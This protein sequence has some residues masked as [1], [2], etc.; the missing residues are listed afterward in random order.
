LPEP[1]TPAITGI[2]GDSM[3]TPPRYSNVSDS[4][5]GLPV[6]EAFGRVVESPGGPDQILDG[7]RRQEVAGGQ[8]RVDAQVLGTAHDAPVPQVFHGPPVP[9][10]ADLGVAGHPADGLFAF[11]GGPAQQQVG[12]ALFRDDVAHIVAVDHHRGQGHARALAHLPGIQALDKG[13]LHVLPEGLYGLD[14]Q[15]PAP[16]HAGVPGVLATG[17][18]PGGGGMPPAPGVRPHVRRA[19]EPGDAPL[20]RRGAVAREV[21]LQGGSDEE[22]AGV[23]A[24]CLGEGPVGPHGA[25]GAHEENVGPGGHVGFHAHLRT[26]AVDG[27]DEAGLDGGYQGGMGI[28]GPVSADLPPQAQLRGIGGEQ[29]LDGGG[30]EANAVVEAGDSVFSVDALDGHHRHQHLDLGDLGRVPGEERLHVVGRGGLHHEVHPPGRNIHPGQLVH[31]LV[32][33]RDDKAVLEGR[34]LHDGG[35]VLGVGPGVQVALG[36]GHLRGDERNLGSEI[37][38]VPAEQ[39]QVGV[40]GPDLDAAPLHQLGQPARLGT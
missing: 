1:T 16:G 12:D 38:E 29:Q 6:P 3:G 37:D 15:L 9:G 33:L 14:H 23:V 21:D 8:A 30:V 7:P 31:D 36:I 34:G 40:D 17:L 25:V 39:F 4:I 18:Q 35:R 19:P 13:G 32:D 28:E 27:F 2:R 20:G 10:Q 26:E 11:F 22:V 5:S 24:G